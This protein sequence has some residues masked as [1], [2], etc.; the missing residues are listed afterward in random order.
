MN[1][2]R[3]AI[4]RSV[5]PLCLLLALMLLIAGFAVLATDRPQPSVELHRATAAADEEYRDRLEQQLLRQRRNRTITIVAT[6]GMA[7]VMAATG[8]VSM[9][10]HHPETP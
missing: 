8:F 10:P 2:L 5:P 7:V 1:R 6:F 4:S 3:N 9:K